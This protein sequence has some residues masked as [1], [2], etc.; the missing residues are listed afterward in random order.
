LKELNQMSFGGY[1]FSIESASFGYVIQSWSGPGW[2]FSFTGT[3]VSGP[4]TDLFSYGARLLTEAAPLPLQKSEDY[5]GLELA[6]TEPFNKTSGE[7][8]F[9]LNVMEEHEVS[10]VH[11]KFLEREGN[12]Y[13]I[14]L[15][16]LIAETVLG[17]PERLELL[18]WTKELP[19]YAYSV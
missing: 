18:V 7:P 1:D 3:C 9:G 5:R 14:E 11:L 17:Q 15:T 8:Y 4:N 13:L 6:V 2:D 16:A 10:E 19:D 12:R